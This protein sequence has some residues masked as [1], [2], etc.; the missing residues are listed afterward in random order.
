M[1]IYI[2]TPINA[3]NEKTFAEKYAAASRRVGEIQG[4]L[5]MHGYKDAEFVSFVDIAPLGECTEAQA[6]GRC[7]QA[8]IESDICLIDE[9]DVDMFLKSSGCITERF[10]A[11]RYR[12]TIIDFHDIVNAK[13]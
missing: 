11:L 6:M 5:I 1:K 2:S 12:K 13:Q 8:V 10:V 9:V 4:Y 3:R 7:V